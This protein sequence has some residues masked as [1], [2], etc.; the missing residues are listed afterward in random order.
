[1]RAMILAAGFGTRLRPLTEELPKPL[2][3]VLGRPLVEHTVRMLARHGVDRVA[4]NLH[5]LPEAAPAALG[6]GTTLGVR[7]DYLV[8]AGEILGTGG[9]IRNARDLLDGDGTFVV[10][11]GDVLMA[12]DLE[13]ALDVH[14]RTR[15]LATMVLREDPRAEAFGAV[16]VDAAGRV[17]RLLGRPESPTAGPLRAAMFTGLHLLEPAVLDMLPASGCIVRHT[18]RRLVDEGLPVAGFVDRGPWVELGT[19]G[20]YLRVNLALASGELVLEHVAGGQ[21]AWI[22][23]DARVDDPR[24]LSPPVVVGARARVAAPLARSVVWDDA[25]VTDPTAGAI[26]TPRRVVVPS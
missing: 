21:G 20:D 11:N 1:M 22:D 16:E 9:G 10:V 7:I 5:H 4:M 14:R 25:V 13:A 8:E 23:P 17:R 18:Y 6:D 15:A 26:V 2:V 12:P 3:P 24:L 19:P